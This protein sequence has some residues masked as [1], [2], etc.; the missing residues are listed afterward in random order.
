[1]K[2]QDTK[3]KWEVRNEVTGGNGITSPTGAD[4][5]KGRCPITPDVALKDVDAE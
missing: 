2:N 4:Y 5:M 1:M 3:D